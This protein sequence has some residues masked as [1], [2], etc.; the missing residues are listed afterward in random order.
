MNCGVTGVEAYLTTLYGSTFTSADQFIWYD[1]TTSSVSGYARNILPT[2]TFLV[3]QGAGHMVPKKAPRASA[4]MLDRLLNNK[5][6]QPTTTT[7]MAKKNGVKHHIADASSSSTKDGDR[8]LNLPHFHHV[9]TGGYAPT[10]VRRHSVT[11]RPTPKTTTPTTLINNKVS[12]VVIP[13]SP[14]AGSTFASGGTIEVDWTITTDLG[15]TVK[16]DIFNTVTGSTVGSTIVEGVDSSNLSWIFGVP[17]NLECGINYEIR[18]T[19][20]RGVVSYTPNWQVTC[21]PMLLLEPSIAG[22]KFPQGGSVLIGWSG[23]GPSWPL[24]VQLVNERTGIIVTYGNQTSNKVQYYA[25]TLPE[26]LDC[27]DTFYFHIAETTADK[28]HAQGQPFQ[29]YCPFDEATEKKADKTPKIV[30]VE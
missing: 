17:N 9:Y 20:S 2:L 21:Q 26:P 27:T 7:T 4:D 24:T 5:P 13:T 30:L 11:H 28:D 19:D 12:P 14:V 8:L 29:V 1:P 25:A 22:T 15:L 10:S 23:G 3:V 16:L 6:F 18:F